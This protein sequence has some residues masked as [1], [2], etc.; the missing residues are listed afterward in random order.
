MNMWILNYES[1]G[2]NFDFKVVYTGST[3]GN[4]LICTQQATVVMG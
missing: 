1:K 2:G 4:S 3:P